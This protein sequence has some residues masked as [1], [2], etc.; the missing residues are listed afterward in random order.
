[1][2]VAA[3]AAQKTRLPVGFVGMS[4]QTEDYADDNT[5][6]SPSLDPPPTPHVFSVP[7]LY[8]TVEAT[9]PA[10]SDFPLLFK[11][12]LDIGCPSTVISGSM[13]T[14]LGLRRFPL[15]AEEDNLSSL[16]DGPIACC[17]YV[18]LVLTSGNGAWVSKTIYAKLCE[19][20]PVPIILG[21]PFLSSEQIVID[22]DDRT[23]I[24]KSSGF[25][26]L[27]PCIPE[28]VWQPD[29]VTPPPTPPKPKRP[30][31]VPFERV[32]PPELDGSHHS[33]RLMA[34]VQNRIERP[35]NA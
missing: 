4:A 7:H 5:Y 34:A 23:A 10:I 14:S 13:A 22:S 20:L 11:A 19:A 3:L 33:R 15:P 2:G 6:V 8:A 31:R 27:N 25:D 35:E 21:M 18:K 32:P 26:L 29:Y 16:T 17:E 30:P 28:R 9:G 24:Q 12:L 1:M